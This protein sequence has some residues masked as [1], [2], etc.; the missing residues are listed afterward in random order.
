MPMLA[1]A[2]AGN[3]FFNISSNTVYDDS[4]WKV[5]IED[6]DNYISSQLGIKQT[7]RSIDLVE[8][9]DHGYDFIKLNVVN[10]PYTND[11]L[12]IT[13]IKEEANKFTFIKHVEGEVIV[14]AIDNPLD[15]STPKTFSITTSAEMATTVKSIFNKV[16]KIRSDRKNTFSFEL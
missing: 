11:S 2:N 16:I 4:E 15:L 1:Y 9:N 14:F 13:N 12:G 7:G 10:A 5:A 6:S 3:R 8:N